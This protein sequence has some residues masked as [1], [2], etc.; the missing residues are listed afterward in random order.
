M[1]N[2]VIGDS[3]NPSDTLVEYA[4]CHKLLP[5]R[6]W[7]HITHSDTFIHGPFEFVKVQGQK[8]CDRISQDDWNV[9][10]RHTSMI[11]NPIPSF[12]VSTYS[13]HVD[14]RAHVSYHN[15]THCD[16]LCIKASYTSESLSNQRY[17]WQ[18]FLAHSRATPNFFLFKIRHILR[19]SGSGGEKWPIVSGPIARDIVF[20]PTAPGVIFVSQLLVHWSFWHPS[21]VR[22]NV[23][24]AG[25][26]FLGHLT[27]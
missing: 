17:P 14:R 19:P 21:F 9:L 25:Q 24:W 6:K 20:G 5:F 22:K 13:I 26:L 12:D 11:Q 15:Q 18:K 3:S 7:L 16:I 4:L 8:T 23:S 1:F 27:A 10:L 2:S